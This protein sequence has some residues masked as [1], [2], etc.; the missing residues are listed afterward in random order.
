MDMAGSVA[1]QSDGKLVLVGT[2]GTSSG[3][4]STFALAR[5]TTAG[6]VDTSFSGDGKATTQLATLSMAMG[7]AIQATGKIVVAGAAGTKSSAD[8][9]IARYNN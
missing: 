6:A 3:Q 7:V 9:A 2:A 5:Y 4:Q 1:V 8:F